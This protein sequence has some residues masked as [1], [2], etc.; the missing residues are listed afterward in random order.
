[1]RE[2][3]VVFCAVQG[4]GFVACLRAVGPD[5]DSTSEKVALQDSE[6]E[7]VEA[8]RDSAASEID[9]TIELF[10][11]E[12]SPTACYDSEPVLFEMFQFVVAYLAEPAAG[13]GL[14]GS[15]VELLG[16]S[17]VLVAFVSWGF[18]S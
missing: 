15:V 7:A 10:V 16:V 4:V 17:L 18:V 1:M 8:V 6:L 12:N 9:L 14:H 13:D 3:W 5:T 2:D 11:F